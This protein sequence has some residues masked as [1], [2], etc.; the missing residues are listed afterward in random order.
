MAY[1]LFLKN[2]PRSWSR[3][4]EASSSGLHLF[5]SRRE[6]SPLLIVREKNSGTG[7]FG[8]SLA[9]VVATRLVSGKWPW[10]LA[11][12]AVRKLESKG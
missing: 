2:T 8:Y 6:P 5:E 3:G 7:L 10:E 1:D 4:I 11:R 9:A 12:L